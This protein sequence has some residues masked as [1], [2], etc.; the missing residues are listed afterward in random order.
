MISFVFTYMKAWPTPVELIVAILQPWKYL[1]NQN[2]AITI[3]MIM[4]IIII[5]VLV[6]IKTRSYAALR[7]ADLD[8]IV[9]P[10][11]SLGL[12]HSGEKP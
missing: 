12:V 1:N 7:A 2:I 10:G 8:W 6:I 4:F 9:G 5:I 3:K 11:Y